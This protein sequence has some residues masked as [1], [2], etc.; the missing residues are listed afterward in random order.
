M[1][2]APEMQEEEEEGRRLLILSTSFKISSFKIRGIFLSFIC[3]LILASTSRSVAHEQWVA[4]VR[5][6]IITVILFP[7]SCCYTHMDLKELKRCVPG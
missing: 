2:E 7:H 1:E 5:L 6:I 3:A 4:L